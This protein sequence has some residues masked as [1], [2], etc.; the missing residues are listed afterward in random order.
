MPV[1]LQDRI[2]A[3]VQR[4]GFV[5]TFQF[6]E[7]GRLVIVKPRK[8][9]IIFGQLLLIHRFGA[10][11]QRQRAFGVAER[12]AGRRRVQK[13]RCGGHQPPEP[14]HVDKLQPALHG[15]HPPAAV[16]RLAR[17]PHDLALHR[18]LAALILERRSL[19]HPISQQPLRAVVVLTGKQAIQF[20][21][22]IGNGDVPV[23]RFRVRVIK[24]LARAKRAGG[25]LVIKCIDRSHSIFRAL[26]RAPFRYSA[27]L[28]GALHVLKSTNGGLSLF[29]LSSYRKFLLLSTNDNRN[30]Y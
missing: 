1:M 20:F 3:L 15:S 28:C 25:F 24:I 17:K 11:I 21:G 9:Q 29:C 14:E 8:L 19:V 7:C 18:K 10:R 27:A 6:R 26:R 30:F 13:D 5:K 16:I 22:D 12:L 23:G 2:R 4:F